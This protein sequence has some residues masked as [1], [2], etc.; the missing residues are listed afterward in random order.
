MA[1]ERSGKGESE[2]SGNIC[3]AS[4]G[5]Y[6][7]PKALRDFPLKWVS[8]ETGRS[9]KTPKKVECEYPCHD[10]YCGDGRRKLYETE[11]C[12]FQ[13]WVFTKKER[14]EI[15]NDFDMMSLGIPPRI[16][17]PNCYEIETK[18]KRRKQ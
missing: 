8:E 17:C 16:L 3:G 15:I 13:N 2:M 10:F 9:I 12:H 14:C 5:R 11:S 18:R 7:N 6:G 1:K 4:R